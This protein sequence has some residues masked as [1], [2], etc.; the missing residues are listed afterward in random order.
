MNR[1]PTREVRIGE[2]AI[3]GENPIAIQSMTTADTDDIDASVRQ[4]IEL[5]RAGAAIVRLTVPS[6][7]AAESL[8]R[9]HREVREAGIGVPLAAD[10]HYTPNAALAAAEFVEKVRINPGNFAD[11][12]DRV[13]PGETFETGAAR[14]A[15]LFGPLASR[16]RE[17]G[18]ALRIGVNHGSLSERITARHGDT[19]EGMVESALEYIAVCERLGFDRVV[20][21]LKSSIP[22]VTVAA[23]R[24]FARKSDAAGGRY[25]LH[26]GVTE[27]GSGEEG[28][29]RSAAGIGALLSEG[30]GDTIRVSLTEDPVLEIPAAREILD[31]ASRARAAREVLPPAAG[32]GGRRTTA[33]LSIGDRRVGGGEP[34][35]VLAAPES[36]PA[37]M[38]PPD[39]RLARSP[40]EAASLAAAGGVVVLEAVR[41][42]TALRA[43]TANPRALLFAFPGSEGTDW[44]EAD[45]LLAEGGVVPLVALQAETSSKIAPIL[46]R[47]RE[48]IPRAL[49]AGAAI[50]APCGPP[51]D[52]APALER[53]LRERG[54][55]WPQFLSLGSELGII[56]NTIAL[57]P[58]L[59]DGLGDLLVA[60][61]PGALRAAWEIL[62]G[63][64]RRITRVE[65]ISC[66]SCGRTLF[67]LERATARVRE[68]TS[69]LK[70]VK[71][72]IMGCVVNGPG[73]MADADFGYVGSGPGRVD[74]YVGS[75][76]V[77]KSIP[78]SEA[79]DRLVGLIRA[80]G[81]W[82][83]PPGSSAA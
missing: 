3:G 62:Q 21:S 37:L 19:P 31:A 76:K 27:A 1:R 51:A 35:A 36:E 39:L 14:V 70:N 58:P 2:V 71:I 7:R 81:R 59:L 53:V 40:G 50:G 74:L 77:E 8:R 75:R 24:L 46:D 78:E 17:R 22:A 52:L 16:L 11:R 29:V 5:A 65:Y 41:P 68:K 38:E 47:L 66:P 54:L 18:A 43:S 26:I 48:A 10:I 25:P 15:E 23:N 55:A 57:A 42:D 83:E 69:H 72:A 20:V 32:E 33:V 49:G 9:I 67:D 34:L 60:R 82:I 12:P 56:E 61:G 64:R 6:I 80:R 13:R 4:V 73:E 30:L 63:T 44:R 45:R 79:V 28:R